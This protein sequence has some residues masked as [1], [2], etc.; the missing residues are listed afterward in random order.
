MTDFKNKEAAAQKEIET[1]KG[2]IDKAFGDALESIQSNVFAVVKEVAA[3][4]HMN[5]VV[6]AR[7]SS[8]PTSRST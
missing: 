3:A 6:S 4:H 8:M 2:S 1:K 7:R 5:I